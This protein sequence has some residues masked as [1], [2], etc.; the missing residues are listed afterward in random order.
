M[1]LKS[2]PSTALEPVIASLPTMMSPRGVANWAIFTRRLFSCVARGSLLTYWIQFARRSSAITSSPQNMAMCR[3][4]L[5]IV[6]PLP[7]VAR[8]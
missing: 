2:V 7:L 5:F 6:D 8:A 4:G 1:Y 3:N